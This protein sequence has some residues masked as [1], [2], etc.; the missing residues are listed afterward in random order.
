MESGLPATRRFERIIESKFERVR[1]GQ[2]PEL[3]EQDCEDQKALLPRM[4]VPELDSVG[5]ALEHGDLK[6]DNI[7]ADEEWKITG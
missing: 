6:F 5:F 2:L 7:I 1:S 3:T 4:L